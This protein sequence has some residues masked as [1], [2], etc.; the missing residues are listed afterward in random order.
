MA[1]GTFHSVRGE[2]SALI[3]IKANK[4]V[5]QASPVYVPRVSCEGMTKGDEFEVPDGYKLI[6]MVSEEGVKR[7]TKDG[8]QLYMLGY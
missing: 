1:I 4:F 8:A 6:P 5:F 3:L 7:T 2:K